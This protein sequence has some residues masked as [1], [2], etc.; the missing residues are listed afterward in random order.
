MIIMWLLRLCNNLFIHQIIAQIQN[1]KQKKIY[2]KYIQRTSVKRT[3]FKCSVVL[4][5]NKTVHKDS[6][7]ITLIHV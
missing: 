2:T 4:Q 5:Q 3:D 7:K 6:L 1:S